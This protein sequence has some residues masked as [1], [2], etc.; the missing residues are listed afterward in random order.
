MKRRNSSPSSTQMKEGSEVQ[1]TVALAP[2]QR[3]ERLQE[4]VRDWHTVTFIQIPATAQV[5]TPLIQRVPE[6]ELESTGVESAS[7][8]V[9][10]EED[11]LDLIP[12]NS[13]FH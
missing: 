9:M 3:G 10:T 7:V 2:Q 6:F 11:F 13:Y 8:S 12:I 1:K 4:F 5:N